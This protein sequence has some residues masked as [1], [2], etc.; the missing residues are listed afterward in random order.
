MKEQATRVAELGG[1]RRSNGDSTMKQKLSLRNILIA[2]VLV[3]FCSCASPSKEKRV[4]DGKP[5]VGAQVGKGAVNGL[6]YLFGVPLFV[7]MTVLAPLG[8]GSPAYGL[9][10]LQKLADYE[11]PDGPPK[12]E[13]WQDTSI[14]QAPRR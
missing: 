7:G 6:R 4:A 12:V 5:S 1:V 3:S 14:L 8:G 2:M 10:G 13:S 11:L 9:K